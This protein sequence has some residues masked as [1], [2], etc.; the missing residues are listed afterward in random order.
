MAEYVASAGLIVR[1]PPRQAGFVGSG[2]A[3]FGLYLRNIL[4]TVVTLGVYFFWAKNRVRAYLVGQCEFE[5]D[6]FAWHG[7]GRELFLG[8]LKLLILA[9]PVVLLIYVMPLVW[10]GTW[11]QIASSVGG[12]IV[13]T[14]IFPMAAVGARRYRL[15]RLSWR[16]IRFSFRGKVRQYFKIYAKGLFLL[17]PTLGFYL[18]FMQTNIRRFT[19]DHTYFGA[20]PFAFEG[21]GRD[22][23]GRFALIPAAAVAGLAFMTYST[24]A[25]MG[26]L[27]SPEITGGPPDPTLMAGFAIMQSFG[28]I[29]LTFAA[30]TLAYLS[31]AA[32]R[33]R[34]FWSHTAFGTARFAS[35]MTMGKLLGFSLANLLLLIVTLGLAFPW[36]VARNVRFNLA[37][38]SLQGPLDLPSIIQD[39]QAAGATAASLADIFDIDF[40]GID[41]PL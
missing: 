28:T 14:L 39:A 22:L 3:L 29:L 8:A 12:L 23:L 40:F 4:L 26:V 7:T 11:T 6:R 35:T 25:A 17:V 16:G 1:P 2:G 38:V 41:L 10:E 20:T 34:Y 5:A 36:I 33:H 32:F 37:N 15:S 18:P 13:Y 27:F 21:K 24:Y 9:V 31:Y 19:T 30:L